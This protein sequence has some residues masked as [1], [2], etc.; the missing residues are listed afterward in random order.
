MP[1]TSSMEHAMQPDTERILV[2]LAAGFEEIEAVAII[3]ILRRADLDVT[4]AGIAAGP[5]RGSHG[6]EIVPDAELGALDLGH[7]TLL[8]LP[9]G[10]PGTRNL[11]ADERV[12]GLVQR[13]ARE[14]R[15]TAAI[16]A[17]PL[18]LQKAGILRGLEVT[19]HPSVRDELSG[20]GGVAVRAEPR[21]LQSGQVI[22]S[23]GA[24]T[25]I[26]FA[27]ALVALLRGPEHAEKIARAIVAARA[28]S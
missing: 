28:E 23:Q 16:C 26:E 9:G 7:F 2:P 4:V 22:T 13:L 24:G 15:T 11:I 8:V 17:A 25:A 27:L 10:M 20:A 18:V 1:G 5:V 3:D 19:A 12:V 21:V 14:G 6:I